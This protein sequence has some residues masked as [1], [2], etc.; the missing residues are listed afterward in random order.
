[1]AKV[2]LNSALINTTHLPIALSLKK[3]VDLKSVD[4]AAAVKGQDAH[5]SNL[6]FQVFNGEVRG[7]GSL[8]F[9]SDSPPF[10]GKATIQGV[11]LGP[12]LEALA[13]IPI[14]ISGTAGADLVLQGRGFSLPDLT[15]TLEGTSHVAVKDGKIEGVNLV[16]EA[17]SILK[18]AGISLDDAKATVFSTFE[19]D[20]AI[21]E[22]TI[23]VQRLL[24][25]SDDFQA[26]GRGTI[27][28]DQILNLKLTMNFSQALSEKTIGS[29]PS[30][31]FLLT[32]G[33]LTVPLLVTGTLQSPSYGLDS[34]LLTGKIQEQMKEKV[35]EAIGDLLKGSAKPGD[36]KP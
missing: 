20:L 17:I 33:Q 21:H 7:Q 24:L 22:G 10:T 36:L 19:T 6:S 9:G 30:A 15:K 35:K 11:Q 31:R 5:L 4:I 34:N 3:P 18:V 13:V 29:S 14:V 25:D 1:D 27:G 2:N 32:K 28:F 26:M 16:Q 12:A 23:Y 8:T